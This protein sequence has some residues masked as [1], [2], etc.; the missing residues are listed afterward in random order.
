[1]SAGPVAVDL[2]AGEAGYL[3]RRLLGPSLHLGLVARRFRHPAAQVDHGGGGHRAEREQ[4]PPGH[5]I[6]D[7]RAEQGQRDQRPDDQPERLGP[8]HH[9]DQLAAVLAVRVLAHHAPR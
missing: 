9:P 7:A 1:M 3:A 6:T 8:E 2:P 4:D 5:V